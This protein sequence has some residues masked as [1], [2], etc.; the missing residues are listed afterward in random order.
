MTGMELGVGLRIA[1][2]VARHFAWWTP[3]L[4]FVFDSSDPSCVRHDVNLRDKTL[5]HGSGLAI[6][7][8]GLRSLHFRVGLRARGHRSIDEVSVE[9]ARVQPPLPC[10]VP[11]PLMLT[12]EPQTIHPS[13]H[14]G[15]WVDVCS[16][17]EGADE[18]ITLESQSRPVEVKLEPGEYRL[19]LIATGRDV[20]S[21]ER[22]FILSVSN[23]GE[24]T[25]T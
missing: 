7:T 8:F 19:T 14:P 12:A 5:R 17:S 10:S 21:A 4:E 1:E 3:K 6:A 13:R 11:F 22:V 2:W 24:P 15:L 25:L 20:L 9:L 18:A 16:K 23:D